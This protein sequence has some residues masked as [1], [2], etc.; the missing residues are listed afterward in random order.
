MLRA[1]H[2]RLKQDHGVDA[3][4]FDETLFH[5]AYLSRMFDEPGDWALPIQMNF[6]VQRGVALLRLK[7]AEP[8]ALVLMERSIDEDELFFEYY[9]ERGHIESTLRGLYRRLKHH[10]ASRLPAV[11][12]NIYLSG[13]VATLQARIESDIQLGKRPAELAGT[14]LRRY[15]EALNEAYEAWA[16]EQR[17]RS[18]SSRLWLE[19]ADT[20]DILGLSNAIA[21]AYGGD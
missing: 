14:R 17:R 18:G 21:R 6:L 7:E 16:A 15:L 13:E 3:R 5:H 12:C 1:L 19:G 20:T 9:V 8:E 10:F 2:A 11:A 4:V